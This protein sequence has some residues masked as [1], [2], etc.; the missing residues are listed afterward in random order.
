MVSEYLPDDL[1]AKLSKHLGL[2]EPETS[3]KR[4][5]LA[6]ANTN[7]EVKRPRIST[8]SSSAEPFKNGGLAL[9]LS[10]PEK[11]FN[12]VV[13]YVTNVFSLIVQD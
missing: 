5:Q 9:D 3:H 6:S 12:T 4:K 1:S 2:P 7:T 8:D 13:L 11:V 10:K